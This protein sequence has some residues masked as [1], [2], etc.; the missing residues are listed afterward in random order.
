MVPAVATEVAKLLAHDSATVR[1]KSICA[2]HRFYQLAPDV[3]PDLADHARRALCDKDPSVMGSCLNVVYSLCL[4]DP[5]PF[6]DL[7][8]SLV[9][10][11]KQIN[12]HRLPSEYDYHRC[13]APWMQILLVRTLGVLGRADVTASN[14]MYEI[15]LTTLRNADTGINAGYAIVYECVKTIVCIYPNPKLMVRCYD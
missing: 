3:V 6:K 8:P 1:K 14:G 12:E 5:A 15:L 4:E 13:P 11:L 2:L 7:V 10:I 9:S